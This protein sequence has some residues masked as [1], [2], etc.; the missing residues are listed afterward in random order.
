MNHPV[1]RAVTLFCSLTERQAHDLASA[2]CV[3]DPQRRGRD[4][5]RPQPVLKAKLNQYT[6]CVGG[7]LNPGAGFLEPFGLFQYADAKAAVR[8]R[9][10]RSEPANAGAGDNDVARGRQLRAP[11]DNANLNVVQLAFRRSRGVRLEIRVVAIE[12]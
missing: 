11:T 7:E 2:C 3:H 12:R 6:R 5:K 1:G 4:G 8:Q 9:Q 10:R